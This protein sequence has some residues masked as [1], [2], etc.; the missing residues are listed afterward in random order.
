MS[1]RNKESEIVKEKDS[2][3]VRLSVI[4]YFFFCGEI[5]DREVERWEARIRQ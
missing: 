1:R 4:L 2:P 3:I 5:I